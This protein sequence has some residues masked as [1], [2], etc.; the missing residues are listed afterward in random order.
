MVAARF[1]TTFKGLIFCRIERY[2]D[3]G[4]FKPDKLDV[5]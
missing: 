1:A 4:W 5:D 2:R 3:A